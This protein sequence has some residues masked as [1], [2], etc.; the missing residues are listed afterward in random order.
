LPIWYSF[1]T[2]SYM[3]YRYFIYI[4]LASL[5]LAP[6]AFSVI[7]RRYFRKRKSYKKRNR[8]SGKIF[9]LSFIVGTL[10]FTFLHSVNCYNLHTHYEYLPEA[11]ISVYYWLRDNTDQGSYYCISPHSSE[12][13]IYY[14]PILNDRFVLDQDNLT[15]INLFND[16]LYDS[17]SG[18]NYQ[19]YKDFLR[20]G[21]KLLDARF[22]FINSSEKYTN[23]K[24]DY[25]VLDDYNNPN[26]VEL[27]DKDDSFELKKN[28]SENHLFS[29][30]TYNVLLF[31][32]K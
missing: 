17:I 4:D 5:F 27:M 24:I 18:G 14:H 9:Q 3:Y 30:E 23:E 31:Y 25:I 2:I 11:H 20:N 8:K 29:E 1:S 10:I 7:K 19:S 15:E 16:S 22:A 12:Q 21:T 26:L 28:V 6:F 32:F 13:R